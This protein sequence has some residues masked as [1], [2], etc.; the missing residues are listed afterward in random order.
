MNRKKR[1]TK[2]GFWGI[3]LLMAAG[4]LFNGCTKD[5][6]PPKDPI[7]TEYIE[8]NGIVTVI[9]HGQ[10]SGT[11]TW[12][13]DKVWLLDH[14]G[15]EDTATQRRFALQCA[16]SV[17]YMMYDKRSITALD[18]E[19]RFQRGEATQ[20]ELNAARSA[21]LGAVRD[22]LEGVAEDAAFASASALRTKVDVAQVARAAVNTAAWDTDATAAWDTYGATWKAMV[23]TQAEGLRALVPVE[24]VTRLLAEQK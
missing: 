5:D 15:W 13:S 22:A 11:M 3:G 7:A 14:L 4:L 12:T 16:R 10:G 17:Q 6:P 18:V 21:A 20:T 8:E 19:E 23:A 24:V 2:I 1:T 9:D